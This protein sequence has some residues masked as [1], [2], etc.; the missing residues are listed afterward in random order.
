MKKQIINVETI[1]AETE[2]GNRMKS[3]NWGVQPTVAPAKKVKADNFHYGFQP[4]ECGMSE[5]YVTINTDKL[6]HELT[7]RGFIMRN[8]MR[9]KSDGSRHVVRMRSQT[10]HTVKGETLYPE[11][12]IHNSYNGKCA[13]KVQMGIFRLVCS[14][15]LT[16]LATEYGSA[17]FKIRH[18]GSEAQIAEQITVEFADNLPALWAVQE[19]LFTTILTDEQKVDLAMKAARLRWNQNFTPEQASALLKA[20]RP[21][22]DGNSAWQVFNVLQEHVT[23]GGIQLE[24]LKRMPKAVKDARKNPVLND[25]LFT[26]IY[27]LVNEINPVAAN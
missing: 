14:N 6:I 3:A 23:Q 20:A 9:R 18:M 2:N 24:G 12:E 10:A 5:K 25:S 17:T 16:V 27:D 4:V 11:I 26:M 1:A 7:K 13:F 21:E 15:G 8:M 19:R 22:D